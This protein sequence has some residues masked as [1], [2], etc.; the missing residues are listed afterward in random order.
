[1]INRAFDRLDI[2]H[3]NELLPQHLILSYHPERH[4]DVLA[5]RRTTADVKAEFLDTFDVGNEVDGRVTRGEFVQYYRSLSALLES[6]DEFE[7]IVC[8]VW[9]LQPSHSGRQ[10]PPSQSHMKIL[11]SF[12]GLSMQSTQPAATR[13]PSVVSDLLSQSPFSTQESPQST[14]TNRSLNSS[15]MKSFLSTSQYPAQSYSTTNPI[16]SPALPPALSAASTHSI[17]TVQ[18]MKAT[19]STSPIVHIYDTPTAVTHPPIIYPPVNILPHLSTTDPSAVLRPEPVSSF[20]TD[21]SLPKPPA[22]IL[23]ILHKIRQH[24]IIQGNLLSLIQLKRRLKQSC[25]RHDNLIS[26]IEFKR[27]LLQHNILSSEVEI[28]MVFEYLDLDY[29]GYIDMQVFLKLFLVPLS[30]SLC[31]LL[32][33]VFSGLRGYSDGCVPVEALAAS[34]TA[35]SHPDVVGGKRLVKDVTREFYGTFDVN[36]DQKGM[37]TLK[38][39]VEYYTYVYTLLRHQSSSKDVDA[40]FSD[41][42]QATWSSLSDPQLGITIANNTNNSAHAFYDENNQPTSRFHKKNLTTLTTDN[43]KPDAFLPAHI[44]RK[45]PTGSVMSNLIGNNDSMGDSG[46]TSGKRGNRRRNDSSIALYDATS[47]LPDNPTASTTLV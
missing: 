44:R 30:P 26:N 14:S 11:L 24:S 16:P 12:D 25:E 10:A 21:L 34:Y 4:P 28:R 17:P 27:T 23:H 43:P 33:E 35:S 40:Y 19:A 7:G 15:V 42:I 37:V 29:D 18:R 6:D 22:N 5:Q 41:L 36:A 2:N 8:G 39:F 9:R 45:P 3:S 32:E 47:A 31:S 38:D 13:K 1:M 46:S 20:N